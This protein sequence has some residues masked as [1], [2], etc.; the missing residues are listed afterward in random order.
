MPDLVQLITAADPARRNQAL[1]AA[2]AG[3]SAADLL[4][5]CARLDDFRRRSEN[6]YERVRALFFLY[7]IHR[8]HLPERLASAAAPAG[9][10][11]LIPFAG[12]EHLLQRRFEEALQLAVQR[13]EGP[14]CA[15][16]RR[17]TAGSRRWRNPLVECAATGSSPPFADQTAPPNSPTTRET[18]P[19]LRECKR[20]SPR[21]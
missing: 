4:G 7:A 20:E 2:C 11:S 10:R 18:Y 1:A 5:Q 6:L 16:A 9:R 14:R 19:I 13:A 3:L 17:T 12:Y 21:G 15:L 8:F